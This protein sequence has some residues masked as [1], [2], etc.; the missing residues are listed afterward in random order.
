MLT[1]LLHT[2]LGLR[3]LEGAYRVSYSLLLLLSNEDIP[4]TLVPSI[5]DSISILGILLEE[6]EGINKNLG[7]AVQR[8][9]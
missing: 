4:E 8:Y 1:L 7:N 5:F 6:S 3:D 2:L 9:T